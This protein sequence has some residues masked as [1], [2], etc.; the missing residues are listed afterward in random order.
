MTETHSHR[1]WKNLRLRRAEWRGHLFALGGYLVCSLLMLIPILP[2]FTQ[3][4]PGG[5]V[6]A[7]DGWQNVWNL[8]WTQQALANGTNPFYTNYLY[9]PDGI[10]LHLHTL[11]ISNGLL[12]LPITTLF[13]PI[14]GYNTAV[15]LAFVLMGMGGYCLALR[16]SG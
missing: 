4:I 6:A 13:G 14:A 2:H 1:Y 9:Y 12:V 10:P 15:L 16:V 7:V 3:A 8:W 11:N 5:P